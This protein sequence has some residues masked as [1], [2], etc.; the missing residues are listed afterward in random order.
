M[1][2]INRFIALLLFLWVGCGVNLKF[3]E[4]Q[5]EE[6]NEM[7]SEPYKIK[8]NSLKFD[9]FDLKKYAKNNQ[10]NLTKY[11]FFYSYT[12]VPDKVI[13]NGA[14]K[15]FEN[16]K[17]VRIYQKDKKFYI[18][19]PLNSSIKDNIEVKY[20]DVSYVSKKGY[21]SGLLIVW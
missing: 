5:P 4:T 11:V 19:F 21:I 9:D 7:L 15:V 12:T 10:I 8:L 1:A 13:P 16:S 2:K 18:F 17:K 6:N 14:Q 20:R 3:I